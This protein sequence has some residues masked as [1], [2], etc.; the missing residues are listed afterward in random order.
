LAVACSL[1]SEGFPEQGRLEAPGGEEGVSR[2][3]DTE[4]PTIV[5]TSGRTD[6][7]P[8]LFAG[9]L[10]EAAGHGSAANPTSG[11]PSKPP[12][13]PPPGVEPS[14]DAT[15]TALPH[16][17][18]ILS[19]VVRGK[20]ERGSELGPRSEL[21]H[22]SP[23]EDK[24]VLESASRQLGAYRI[25]GELGSGGMAVVYKAVQ[26]ALDRMV[27]IKELRHEYVSDRQI[28][29]RFEREAT[30]LATLQ[31]GNIVHIYDFIADGG[32][33][34]I[35]MEF[36]EGIDLFDLLH[37]TG[38]LAPDVAA[39]IAFQLAEG[40]AYA[41]Y[42]GIIHRDVKPS[43]LLIS[44]MGEVKI[45]DFGIARDP[46]RS[47]LT[48]VGMAL[49]T[50]AYM[51]PEQIRGDKIDFRADIFAFGIVLYEMT[52][53]KKPWGDDDGTAVA[54]KILYEEFTPPTV[55]VPDLPVELVQII[56][57]CLAKDPEKRFA[58]AYHLRRALGDYLSREL[59]IDHR[60]RVVVF[61]RNRGI[62]TEGEASSFVHGQVLY[63]G[64]LR[65][66]DLGLRAVSSAELTR[67]LIFAHGLAV[68]ALFGLLAF[69]LAKKTDEPRPTVKMLHKR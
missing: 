65:R 19:A 66:K 48:Q 56:S 58:S 17:S 30:S 22:P 51:A 38:R 53:G 4:A 35:V 55:Y 42:R 31:H 11:T 33:A 46:G 28:M 18:A 57:T 69:G 68:L 29:A 10:A 52:T 5:P 25:L 3:D 62:I 34:Y 9:L 1:V 60:Q 50:P 45:M 14:A 24:S 8:Q 6:Q 49:G 43:N 54:R 40:L 36:V 32:G 61:L 41:H 26:P 23:A 13:A 64:V 59:A 44:K 12:P 21:P 16:P 27:A 39:V 67:P 15:V 2:R 63:D 37:Q 20:V 7:K 47:D